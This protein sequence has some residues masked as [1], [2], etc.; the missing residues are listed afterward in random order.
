M[1]SSSENVRFGRFLY[2]LTVAVALAL[3]AFPATGTAK[4]KSGNAGH[5]TRASVGQLR[6]VN[7]TPY[8]AFY[9]GGQSDG[10]N[11][12]EIQSACRMGSDVVRVFVSWQVLEPSRGQVN[13]DYASELDSLMSQA[14][15]CG[16]KVMLMLF[17]TPPWDSSDPA[18]ASD[19]AAVRYPARDPDHFRWMVSWILSRWPTLHSFEVWNEP[20]LQSYFQGSP[21]DY[22]AMVNAAVAVK[23]QL[24]SSTLILAGTLAPGGSDFLSQL[25]A[26]GM[27]GQDGISLHPY[28]MYCYSSCTLTNPSPAQAPFRAAITAIHNVMAAH[29]DQSGL[30]LTEFGFA[31]CPA[32][33]ACIS[34]GQQANWMVKSI[35]IAACYP[36]IKGVT[37]FLLR[38][39]PVADPQWALVWDG[40]FGLLRSDFSPK[41]SFPAMTSLYHGY[42]VAERSAGRSRA[43]SKVRSRASLPGSRACAR[44]VGEG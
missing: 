18:G 42:D 8:R 31:T 33:P 39:I 21:A 6:G 17:G 23:R 28:S 5:A 37:P 1:A 2:A 38:D 27:S 35:R 44:L 19:P 12:R 36:Y 30:W 24:G 32:V 16:M 34:E 14:S 29:G 7:L 3:L 40:H 41:R 10:D 13:P 4:K 20:N 15:A 11:Q 22:A 43:K 9:P 26:A 25:Y